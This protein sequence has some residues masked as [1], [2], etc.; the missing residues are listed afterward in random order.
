MGSYYTEHVVVFLRRH[1]EPPSAGRD[2]RII[3]ADSYGPRSG[4]A[5]FE[6]CWSL[7]YVLILIGGGA[8]G[9]I[10]VMDTHLNH[11]LVE[12]YT[13]LEM[14]DFLEQQRACAGGCNAKLVYQASRNPAHN[15]S[16]WFVPWGSNR[17]ILERAHY[18]PANGGRR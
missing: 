1:L 7:Q 17:G 5:V 11:A 15:M 12:R 16:H 2:W 14:L 6:L 9:A 4:G 10:Q 3:M 18:C 8:A 13:D